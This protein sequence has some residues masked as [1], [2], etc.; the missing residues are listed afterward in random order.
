MSEDNVVFIF[1]SEQ[2]NCEVFL[3][4]LACQALEKDL[5]TRNNAFLTNPVILHSLAI[6]L[7][8]LNMM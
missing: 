5:Q 3:V 4:F 1:F 6:Q 2:I 7:P 8:K